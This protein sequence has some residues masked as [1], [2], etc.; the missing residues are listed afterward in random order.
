MGC[1]IS[2]IAVLVIEPADIYAISLTEE[3]I[4]IDQLLAEAPS[5]KEIV[6]KAN[7]A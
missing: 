1:A 4:T 7:E 3:K 5:L 6:E 2:P